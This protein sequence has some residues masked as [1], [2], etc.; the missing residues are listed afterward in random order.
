MLNQAAMIDESGHFKSKQKS[1]QLRKVFLMQPILII[2]Y[3]INT[4]MRMLIQN[5]D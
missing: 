4:R 2:I 5:P 3:V 1:E